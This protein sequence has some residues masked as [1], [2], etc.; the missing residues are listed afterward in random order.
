M[1]EGVKKFNVNI[2]YWTAQHFNKQVYAAN[3][4]QAEEIAMKMFK[5]S[6]VQTTCKDP[7]INSISELT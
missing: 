5:D 4:G 6:V 3:P 7:E 2:R 1:P